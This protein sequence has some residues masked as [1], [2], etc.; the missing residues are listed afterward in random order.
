MELHPLSNRIRNVL[1]IYFAHL[2]RLIISCRKFH[3]AIFFTLLSC[4]YIILFRFSIIFKISYSSAR[5]RHS[6]LFGLIKTHIFHLIQV[7]LIVF[8]FQNIS[9][10]SWLMALTFYS[11]MRSSSTTLLIIAWFS[12]FWNLFL[13]MGS[14]LQF[15][16]GWAAAYLSFKSSQDI[17][18]IRIMSSAM[19]H[20]DFWCTLRLIYISFTALDSVPVL[21]W[22]SIWQRRFLP[23]YSYW[24]QYGWLV[25]E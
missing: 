19:D 20:R 10:A 22:V 23:S 12:C 1:F 9:G 3:L 25:P 5:L 18:F 4:I 16:V 15:L 13:G 7:I 11:I 2:G 6:I 24:V 21:H 8:T 14:L 17:T